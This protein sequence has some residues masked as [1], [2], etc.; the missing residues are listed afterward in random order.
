VG[1]FDEAERYFMNCLL[2]YNIENYPLENARIQE[3]IAEIYFANKD[4]DDLQTRLNFSIESY[5]K[6]L[7]IYSDNNS[8]TDSDRVIEGL[9]K[10]YSLLGDHC[11]NAGDVES[12]I[13]IHE[14]ASEFFKGANKLKYYADSLVSI[15]EI[16]K[17]LNDETPSKENVQKA[18]DNFNKARESYPGGNFSDHA[19]RI[20]K[21]VQGLEEQGGIVGWTAP[22]SAL[23]TSANEAG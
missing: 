21:L 18:L 1:N 2:L 20:S 16:Y 15:G 6:S 3:K 8:E 9:Y 22:L 12:S 14:E 10:V 19:D 11:L 5:K 23:S 7:S 13:K 17:S 4:S